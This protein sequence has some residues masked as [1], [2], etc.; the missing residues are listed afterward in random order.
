MVLKAGSSFWV[1]QSVTS[2]GARR[3]LVADARFGM[4]EHGVRGGFAGREQQQQRDYRE[5]EMSVA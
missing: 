1:N 3:D 4:V 5:Q 2:R